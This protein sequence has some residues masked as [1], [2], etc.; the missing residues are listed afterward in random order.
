MKNIK[1]C[2]LCK[3]KKLKNVILFGKVPF[4]DHWLKKSDLNIKIKKY[5][6]TVSFCIS[7]K[8]LQLRQFVDEQQLYKRFFYE[9]S[10]T[11][12][13]NNHYNKFINYF[14]KKFSSKIVNKKILDIGSNNGFFL[15]CFKKKGYQIF[16]VEP[17]KHISDHANR[18]GIKTYNFFFNKKNSD[19][20]LKENGKFSVI[21]I[22]YLLANINNFHHFVSSVNKLLENEGFLIIETS[23]L[24]Q[25]IKKKLYDT[26]F[27]EHI[28]YFTLENLIK[29]FENYNIHIY[30]V[31]EI[32]PKGG[33]LRI[34][35]RKNIRKMNKNNQ[36]KILKILKDE[37]KYKLQSIKTYINFFEFLKK[38]KSK[39]KKNIVQ[40]ESKIAAFGASVA[41]N[42]LIYYF[43][44][45]KKIK[46]FVDD[47]K[48]MYNLYAPYSKI[49]VKD[50]NFFFNDN[51]T[52][53]ILI[54]A[55]RYTDMIL[56]KYK[57][58][59][60]SKIIYRIYPKIIKIKNLKKFKK[61]KFGSI[62]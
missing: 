42:T 55:I 52:K 36:E 20:L 6:L 26:F 34:I 53:S 11:S 44:L 19:I 7:C 43:N 4:G 62:V 38:V 25:I 57:N 47:N 9:I 31:E 8:V 1:E 13:L 3:S 49:P 41:S 29:I 30:E 12:G 27:H 59:F 39:I 33:S 18:K 17:V 10:V 61:I 56:N 16:G 60:K 40:K 48:I 23:H 58:K 51:K 2:R 54:L 5:P 21:A 35:L 15:N 24:K 22:N 14:T 46:Y 37:K 28:F 45:F 32:L 50:P